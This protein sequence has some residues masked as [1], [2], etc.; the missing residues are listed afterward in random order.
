DSA[1]GRDIHNAIAPNVIQHI[2][3]NYDPEA[4][5]PLRPHPV[6]RPAKD[7]AAVDVGEVI[8]LD[9]QIDKPARLGVAD[10]VIVNA[11]VNLVRV[12]S[13]HVVDV[14]ILEIKMMKVSGALCDQ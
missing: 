8:V 9:A 6:C 5:I 14:E 10:G 2:A 13:V 3:A 12:G 7:P 1:I 11:A 4:G